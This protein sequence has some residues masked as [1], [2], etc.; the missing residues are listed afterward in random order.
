MFCPYCGNNVVDSARHCPFC[1][2]NLKDEMPVDEPSSAPSRNAEADRQSDAP[3]PQPPEPPKAAPQ[4]AQANSDTAGTS[5]KKSPVRAIVIAIVSFFI[6]GAVARSCAM[7][8][9]QRSTEASRGGYSSSTSS[10]SDTTSEKDEE[11]SD[12]TEGSDDTEAKDDDSAENKKKK[13]KDKSDDDAKSEEKEKEDPEPKELWLD[14]SLYP[15]EFEAQGL[16]AHLP[17][18]WYEVTSND[19]EDETEFQSFDGKGNMTVYAMENPGFS[20]ED[21]VDFMNYTIESS[22]EEYASFE[23]IE[24]PHTIDTGGKGYQAVQFLERSTSIDEQYAPSTHLINLILTDDGRV[25]LVECAC[26]TEFED[27]KLDELRSI[28]ER[29]EVGEVGETGEQMYEPA[30]HRIHIL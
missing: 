22:R 19:A 16:V 13:D 21:L 17:V 10:D 26:L 15:K 29:I 1:G 4:T 12:D 24:E 6:A 27:T 23:V 14:G 30:I 5:A 7:S 3:K 20:S 28:M 8:A 9:A 25:R 18:Y 11:T 2:A